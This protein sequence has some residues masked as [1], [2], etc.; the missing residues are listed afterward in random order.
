MFYKT[1][2]ILCSNLDLDGI[3][4]HLLAYGANI[5]Y[6]NDHGMFPLIAACETD[7]VSILIN[8]GANVNISNKYGKTS[9]ITLLLNDNLDNIE[10]LVK[11]GADVN[12]VDTNC[13]T[14]LMIACSCTGNLEI[15]NY[16]LDNGANVNEFDVY[17]W[18]ALMYAF[19]R[20]NEIF[21][22]RIISTLINNG[23]NINRTD[24]H[25][26]SILMYACYYTTDSYNKVKFLLQNGANINNIY[27]YK[28]ANYDLIDKHEYTALMLV[29]TYPNIEYNLEITKL[30]LDNSANVEYTNTYYESAILLALEHSDSKI[31]LRLID[32][33]QDSYH[34]IIH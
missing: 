11:N 23:A 26:W 20:S 32:C 31:G 6:I 15:I 30:L 14:P 34:K 17:G 27:T 5:N 12:L 21:D 13:S 28:G 18:D 7:I 4:K 33:L 16:L 29:C 19:T 8:N 24:K 1:F 25:G 22:S 3:V 9:L 10:L 2:K